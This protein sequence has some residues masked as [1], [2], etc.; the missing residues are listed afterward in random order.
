MSVDLALINTQTFTPDFIVEA[1]STTPPVTAYNNQMYLVSAAGGGGTGAWEG[2][3][4]NIAVSELGTSWRFI[5]PTPRL[6]IYEKLNGLYY[7][8]SGI[9]WGVT[10]AFDMLGTSTAIP[11]GHFAPVNNYNSAA[12]PFPLQAGAP[13]GVYRFTTAAAAS[14]T[15]E[16]T[17]EKGCVILDVVVYQHA[18]AGGAGCTIGLATENPAGADVP[19]FP[20]FTCD[21]AT[22][23][24]QRPA[25]NSGATGANVIPAGDIIKVIATD[26][27]GKLPA[28]TVLVTFALGA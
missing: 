20:V 24:I 3:D 7:D 28:T 14:G 26:N 13:V 4:N 6:T 11:S 9:E 23:A 15:Y 19:L 2:Q 12:A 25:V 8:W 10:S 18:V 17:V 27:A 5:T 16:I 21:Q 22:V 1:V